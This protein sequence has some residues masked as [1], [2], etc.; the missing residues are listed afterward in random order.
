M[1]VF[2]GKVI[3]T[4]REKTATVSVETKWKHP[5][6]SKIL[7]DSKK[8][9]CHDTLETKV[10]DIVTIEEAKPISKSK[11]FIVKEILEKAPVIK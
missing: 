10:G 9:H 2:K 7:K 3:S 1:K 6:Y 4:N 8:Y 11:R 5:I